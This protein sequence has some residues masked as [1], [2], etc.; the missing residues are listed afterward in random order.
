[1]EKFFVISLLDK[2]Q[3]ARESLR[4]LASLKESISAALD[5]TENL[6]KGNVSSQF[7]S[8]LRMEL[9]TQYVQVVRKNVDC[10]SQR[11]SSRND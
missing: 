3:L 8:H 1:M 9:L 2:E 7:H 5:F 11:L 10:F 4:E 6:M